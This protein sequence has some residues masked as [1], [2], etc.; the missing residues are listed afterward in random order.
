MASVAKIKLVSYFID[1]PSVEFQGYP[2]FETKVNAELATIPIGDL[3][4]V[5]TSCLVH[6]GWNG[7]MQHL[8]TIVYK[9]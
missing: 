3:I 4:A 5:N 6:P 2:E 1:S 7:G 9:S 8:A